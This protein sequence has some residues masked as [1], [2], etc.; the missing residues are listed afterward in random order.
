MYVRQKC[1]F[2]SFALLDFGEDQSGGRGGWEGYGNLEW[3]MP[4]LARGGGG[5]KYYLLRSRMG[6]GK[7][8]GE[9]VKELLFVMCQ[10]QKRLQCEF[11]SMVRQGVVLAIWG[12]ASY[13]GNNDIGGGGNER[14]CFG[15]DNDDFAADI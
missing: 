14:R 5:L 15:E 4:M 9:N 12:D 3:A 13:A 11:A 6:Y 8:Q 1:S 10:E 2:T 7:G